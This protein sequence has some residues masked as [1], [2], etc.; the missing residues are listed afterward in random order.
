MA[1]RGWPQLLVALA[2][3]L[4]ETERSKAVQQALAEAGR[5][6]D[7]WPRG[8]T[9]DALAPYIPEAVLYSTWVLTDQAVLERTLIHLAPTL[10]EAV[11]AVTKARARHGLLP[12]SV[13]VAV[14]PH[15]PRRERED[16]LLQALSSSPWLV[17]KT[18]MQFFF[19]IKPSLSAKILATSIKYAKEWWEG[20]VR[21]LI[22]KKGLS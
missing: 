3:H 6:M 22:P 19:A 17:A 5:L 21:E 13:L 1:A 4:N 20:I 16:V 9:L 18:R 8:D 15:L 2:P 11:L 14:A 10:P 12:A 7:E